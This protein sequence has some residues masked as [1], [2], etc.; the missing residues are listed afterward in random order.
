MQKLILVRIFMDTVTC[1]YGQMYPYNLTVCTCRYNTLFIIQAQD[2]LLVKILKLLDL[3]RIMYMDMYVNF[4][5]HILLCIA[6]LHFCG[7][8]VSFNLYYMYLHFQG[9]MQCLD[10]NFIVVD[11]NRLLCKLAG[12]E[13]FV[14]PYELSMNSVGLYVLDPAVA[15]RKVQ[16]IV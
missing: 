14:Q 13:D 3:S 15:E 12:I 10:Q 6:C 7:L 9:Q 8:S 16:Y 11:L 5:L 2:E 1:F 4:V